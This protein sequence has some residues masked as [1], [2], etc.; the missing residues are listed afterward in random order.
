MCIR[1]RRKPGF[2]VCSGAGSAQGGRAHLTVARLHAVA[3]PDTC[4]Q[5]AEC[6]LPVVVF[7]AAAATKLLAGYG[8]IDLGPAVTKG[9][10]LAG[11]SG[12]QRGV[13]QVLRVR[14]SWLCQPP[15]KGCRPSGVARG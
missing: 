13:D 2:D 3:V 7:A 5:T 8:M 11:T 15:G 1:D 6:I 10:F 9:S 14:V 12:T 4:S